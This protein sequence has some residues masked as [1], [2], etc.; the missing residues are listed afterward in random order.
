M[1]MRIGMVWSSFRNH[2]QK[3]DSFSSF[4]S[5]F[6]PFSFYC[7]PPAPPHP[8]IPLFPHPATIPLRRGRYSSAAQPPASSFYSCSPG[9][10]SKWQQ[11][12]STVAMLTRSD[13][14]T[15]SGSACMEAAQW[16]SHKTYCHRGPNGGSEPS[17]IRRHDL[18]WVKGNGALHQLASC[19]WGHRPHA[20]C[21]CRRSHTRASFFRGNIAIGCPPFAGK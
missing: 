21:K 19:S 9:S 17:P 6:V 8:Y 14:R 11:W 13:A 16:H 4:L 7:P 1:F 18:L 2:T 10:V 20:A 15:G 3:R 12:E 5:S